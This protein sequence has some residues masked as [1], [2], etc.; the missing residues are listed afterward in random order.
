MV[1]KMLL[2]L[3]FLPHLIM[4]C[5]PTTKSTYKDI[6][7]RHAFLKIEKDLTIKGDGKQHCGDI[8]R[9]S[10]TA[11]AFIVRNTPHGAYV[12]TAQH[13]CDISYIK[14]FVKNIENGTFHMDFKVIDIDG[15]KYDVDI[16]TGN[17]RDDVCLLWVEDLYKQSLSVSPKPPEPGD[18]VFNVGAPLGIFQVNMIPIQEGIYNGEY[19]YAAYYSLPA[20]G[21]SSGSPIVNYKGELVG[22]VHSVYREFNAV[23]VSPTYS[24]LVDFINSKIERHH[25]RYMIDLY[26]RVLVGLKESN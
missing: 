24:N 8:A 17:E 15:K 6:L 22:M 9:Y 11:S 25:I 3:I 23:S 14:S 26:M 10:S 21:G 16:V 13:V 18:R 2:L 1:K 12:I 7:P 4:G 5:A 20:A 19:Q